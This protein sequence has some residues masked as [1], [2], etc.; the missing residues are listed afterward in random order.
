MEINI[1]PYRRVAMVTVNGR[2]DSATANVFEETLQ[3]L[4]QEGNKNLILDMQGV[5]FL[6]SSGLRVLV[7]IQ[8]SVRQ[9]GGDVSLAQPSSRTRE[10]LEIAGLDG[11][12]RIHPDRETAIASY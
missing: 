10:S 2:V 7:T 6:S 8:K 12:F 5:G 4:I 11:F 3:G 9:L 1:K